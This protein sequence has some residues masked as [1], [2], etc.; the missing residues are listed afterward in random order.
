MWWCVCP[1][2]HWEIACPSLI[3]IR[4]SHE[5]NP[6]TFMLRGK[7]YIS[8]IKYITKKSFHIEFFISYPE[9]GLIIMISIIILLNM[10]K[11]S[12]LILIRNDGT[13]NTIILSYS[14]K[15]I[16]LPL[17]RCIAWNSSNKINTFIN[18]FYCIK[19]HNTNLI[20]EGSDQHLYRLCA[21]I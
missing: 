18:V 12:M 21:G 19:I 1:T 4:Y 17:L 5:L 10:N 9:F 6:I 20:I 15:I 11:S 13:S 16:F 14:Y 7:P 2:P 8:K 3:I